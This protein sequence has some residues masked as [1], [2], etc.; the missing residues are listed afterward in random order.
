MR[1]YDEEA[2]YGV[3]ISFYEKGRFYF[4]SAYYHRTTMHKDIEG[5]KKSSEIF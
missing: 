4:C 2:I 5:N 3:H 1:M